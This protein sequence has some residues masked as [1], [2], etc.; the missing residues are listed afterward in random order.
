MFGPPPPLL[1]HEGAVG[2]VHQADDGVID[3]AV[4]VHGFDQSGAAAHDLYH[5]GQI[6]LLRRMFEGRE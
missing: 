1:V 5:A 6:R 3:V 2:G 4:E